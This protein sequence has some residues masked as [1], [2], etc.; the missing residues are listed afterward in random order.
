M[1]TV[2]VPLATAA[3]GDGEIR[4]GVLPAGRYAT[5]T[6]TGHPDKLVGVTATLLDWAAQE[7]L[8]WDMTETAQGQRWG[9]R[10]DHRQ[11]RFGIHKQPKDDRPGNKP[12][13]DQQRPPQVAGGPGRIERHRQRQGRRD[14][15]VVQD[16]VGLHDGEHATSTPNGHRR[17]ASSRA[18]IAHPSRS[19]P[20]RVPVSRPG[21]R[22]PGRGAR[23]R[24]S[25]RRPRDATGWS[26]CSSAAPGGGR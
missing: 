4:A 10:A 12:A 18:P 19:P 24:R 25:R 6:H 26:P 20:G 11:H 13:D 9:C 15:R 21:R 23:R 16:V 22:G 1:Q 7:G 8:R 5:V 2:G 14:A 3:K 17:R